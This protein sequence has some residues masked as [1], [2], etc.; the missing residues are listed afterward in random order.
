[1]NKGKQKIVGAL[2]NEIKILNSYSGP[3]Y[4]ILQIN[5]DELC[6][7]LFKAKLSI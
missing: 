6:A 3:F 2:K 7:F 1:M 4:Y 5:F